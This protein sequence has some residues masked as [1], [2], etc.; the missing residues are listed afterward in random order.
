[1][2]RAKGVNNWKYNDTPE[3]ISQTGQRAESSTLGVYGQRKRRSVW[4]IASQPFTGDWKTSHQVDVEL[5]AVSC[6]TKRIA[7][8]SCPVHGLLDHPWSIH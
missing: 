4:S 8:S 3:R 2:Q 7:S 1:M 5:G 6:G